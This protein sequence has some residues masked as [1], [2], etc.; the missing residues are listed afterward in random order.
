MT[1]QNKSLSKLQT[2]IEKRRKLIQADSYPMSIGEMANLYIDGEIN[3]HPEFQRFYRWSD[4]QKSKLIDSILLGLPLPSFFIAQNENGTWEVIDGLQR[5]A[6]I[7]SFM[8]IYKNADGEFEPPLLLSATEYLPDL[9]GTVWDEKASEKYQGSQCLPTN[10]RLSFKRE[11]LD[12]KIIKKESTFDTKYEL[13]N[14]LNTSASRLSNQEVRNCM[15]I[16][17]DKSFY[18]WL[19]GLSNYTSF[20]R[21]IVLSDR[22]YNEKYDMELVLRFLIFTNQP[23]DKLKYIS[24]VGDYITTKMKDSLISDN[25]NRPHEEKRFKDCFDKL[26][27]SL[28]ENSFKKYNKEQAQYKGSFS[29]PIFEVLAI[30]LGSHVSNTTIQVDKLETLSKELPNNAS[31]IKNSGSGANISA[32]L[33]ALIELGDSMFKGL[34]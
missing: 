23:I 20:K 28:G 14:R 18:T 26:Y 11:K 1:E 15:L 7:F 9:K 21:A 4:I 10:L 8:G 13:F 27:N 3:I 6:T 30:G 16:M 17:L 25:Y 34:S 32:R 33:P 19:L 5:L 12:L 2:S 29:L 22:N 24:D 31:F